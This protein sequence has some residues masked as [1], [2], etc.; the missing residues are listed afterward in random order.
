MISTSLTDLKIIDLFKEMCLF[1]CWNHYF[2]MFLNFVILNNLILTKIKP[3]KLVKV[4][5]KD[6]Y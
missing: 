3:C 6:E 4:V 5:S 1:I 2:L